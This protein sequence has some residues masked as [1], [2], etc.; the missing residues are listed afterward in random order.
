MSTILS[1][2][3]TLVA[4]AVVFALIKTGLDIVAQILATVLGFII[5]Y[6]LLPIVLAGLSYW[7][8]ERFWLGLI[9][10]LI[11]TL[12]LKSAASKDSNSND[13]NYASGSDSDFYTEEEAIEILDKILDEDNC[14]YTEDDS[15]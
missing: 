10:G 5:H 7:I 6:W 13:S 8:F 3:L 15:N 4:I 9:I 11:I 12:I 14:P 1:I 2:I